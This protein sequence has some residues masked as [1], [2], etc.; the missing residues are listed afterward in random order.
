MKTRSIKIWCSLG[1]MLIGGVAGAQQINPLVTKNRFLD[2]VRIGI[3]YQAQEFHTLNQ[4]LA[5]NC[6]CDESLRLNERSLQGIVV[7][8]LEPLNN[9]RWALGADFGASFGRVMND[10][11]NYQRYSFVQMRV[12]SFYHLFDETSKLRPYLS[13]GVQLAA[14]SRR[15]LFG[16]PVGAGVRYSLAKGGTLHVQTTYDGGMGS[17]IAKNMITNIGF[18]VPLYKRNKQIDA[19]IQLSYDQLV[20]T[21]VIDSSTVVMAKVEAVTPTVTQ[22]VPIQAPATPVVVPFTIETKAPEQ[23]YRIVYFDTD[24]YS[25]NKTET[26][27]VLSEVYAFLRKHPGKKAY[28]VGHTDAVL[29]QDYNLILSKNRVKA[30]A[31]WLAENGIAP[32]RITSSYLGKQNPATSN[33]SEGGRSGNRRVEIFIK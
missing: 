4:K 17:A 10:E 8:I 30:V 13:G 26:S 12:E 33:E 2:T 25:L 31:N 16:V 7:S 9:T 6:N 3:R 19:P 20:K 5:D 1:L 23:L 21:K 24:K 11:R 14:N 18:H 15:G 29:A 22:Q 32:S 28:L 27:K